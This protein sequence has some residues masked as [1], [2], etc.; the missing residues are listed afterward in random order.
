[1]NTG[2]IAATGPTQVVVLDGTCT[3]PREDIGGKAWSLNRMRALGLP[4]PAAIVVTTNACR[5]HHATGGEVSDALWTHIVEHM[6]LLEEGSSRRFAGAQRPLLVSVRSGAAHSMPGMMDTILNLGINDDIELVLAAE[7]GDARYGEE[8]HRRFIEQYR[9]IVLGGRPGPVPADPWAQLRAA[10]AAVFQSWHSPRARVYR[11]NR[12]LT[13]DGC[14][15]V[16]IQAMVFGNL[17]ARSGTGVLF[18]RNPVTG[19]PPAWGE[20]LTRGQGEDVVSG[21]HTPEPLHALR[22]SMPRVHAEL[23]QATAI[24]EADARDIQDIEFTVESERLWLLQS[25]VAKRSPQAAVRAAVAFAEEGLISTEG[26]VRR[27]SVEQVRQLSSLRLAPQAAGQRLLAVGEAACPGI[28][29]GVV[30]TDPQDAEMRARHGED[31]ILAR[32]TTSP[33]DLHGIIAARALMTEQGG[34]TSHAAVV[35]RELGRPCV[36]G[37]G[38]NTVTLLAGQRVTLDGASGRVWAGNL[39]LDGGDE[40]S[41]GDLR[42]LVEWGMPLI[43]MRLLKMDEA[44]AD[45]VD[46]DAWGENWRTALAPGVAVRG[47][48]LE[49]EQGIR[50]ALAAG[51]RAA[52]V[53][54]R[55]PAVL[56]C[57]QPAPAAAQPKPARDAA[58]AGPSPDLSELSLLRL[59]GLKGRA[60]AEVLADALSRPADVVAAAYLHLHE[61]GLCTQAGGALRLTAAGRDRLAL[62]L[63][64]ERRHTDPAAVLALYEDFCVLNAE[65]KRIL[66]AWQLKGDAAPNDHR[67]ADYDAGV[68]RRLADLH[69]R[70]APLLQRLAALSP[71]LEQ[72]GVRLARAAA[73]VAAGDHSYVAKLI[74][75]SYHTVWFELHED[76][77]SLAGLT[78]RAEMQKAARPQSD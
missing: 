72:Y 70:A 3:L 74:A 8:T 42:K 56:A 68:L 36:V 7:C 9:K 43:P 19:D 12:G 73:R 51:V 10:V 11:R 26:A 60:S 18:S 75:D 21:R 47:R 76:L 66:T 44:P 32:A 52:I 54:H 33:D 55:L 50:A 30:V 29:C 53:R 40:D 22:A 64:E 23:M 14:T 20:W 16:T 35:S 63:G 25:R 62:L 13:D 28:A 67:D 4:V 48:V 34:A 58:D 17:D 1:L 46:L 24:L 27:L 38:S 77:I 41:T 5:E 15:A 57:L 39:A 45:T 69:G 49:T 65:L 2:E 37:C 6:K 71:R 61:I 31:V 59:V 78:R